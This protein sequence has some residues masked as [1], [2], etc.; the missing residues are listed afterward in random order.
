MTSPM[1]PCII[2]SLQHAIE[3]TSH[4]KA[5]TIAHLAYPYPVPYKMKNASLH[6]PEKKKK[7]RI[8]HLEM[9]CPDTVSV[10]SIVHLSLT[11]HS[12][13]SD[14]FNLC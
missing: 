3:T 6:N 14:L 1:C 10:S 12:R 4:E 2:T 8:I 9:K 13:H 11:S 7:K 5:K